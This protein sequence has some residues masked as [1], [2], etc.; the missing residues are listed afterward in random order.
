VS[1]ALLFHFFLIK[2]TFRI[3]Q[4]YSM[5]AFPLVSILI[6]NYNYERFLSEAIS[7]ALDQTYATYEVI[8]V[9][10]GSTDNSLSV[11]GAYGDRVQLIAKQNGGQASAFNAGFEA[12]SG[13]VIC[14]L[15]SD[16]LFLPDKLARV[17]EIFSENPD[18]GWCFDT[19]EW[20]GGSAG[21]R[22]AGPDVCKSGVVDAREML[23]S[24]SA[25]Y[26]P[27]ATSGLS[28]RRQLLE[29]ILP[30]PNMIRITSDNYIKIAALSLA[31]GWLIPQTLS[32]QRIHGENAYTNS[33]SSRKR[34]RGRTE[35][36]T[37]IC[38]DRNFPALHRFGLN[39]VCHGLVTLSV[40]G[41]IDLEIRELVLFYMRSIGIFTWSR[42]F[43]KSF[44]KTAVGKLMRSRLA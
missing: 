31:Q 15:D 17:V 34:V 12:S 39:S 22:Y 36:L 43:A 18:F 4:E 20:F 11:V 5:N 16:D 44:C 35:V 37:G 41:G 29:Q 9:D 38:L 6:N 33:K 1:E 26:I 30:M 19:P 32:M 42:A 21:Q 8:V 13:E 23:S 25:P 14:F 27:S 2:N 10:D 24:G 7:S 40:T 28:F 3:A